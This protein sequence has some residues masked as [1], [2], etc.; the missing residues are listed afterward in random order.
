MGN[1]RISTK[2]CRDLQMGLE[3]RARTGR[4]RVASAGPFSSPC[5]GAGTAR[6]LH[7]HGVQPQRDHK[8][9]VPQLFFELFFLEIAWRPAV[10]PGKF[11]AQEHHMA[12]AR[13]ARRFIKL[14]QASLPLASH[15]PSQPTFLA[16]L[17]PTAPPR[18]SCM[19]LRD[20]AKVHASVARDALP[21][22]GS[23]SK[24]SPDI[25]LHTTFNWGP[26]NTGADLNALILSPFRQ[27][28][29]RVARCR[30]VSPH[31]A[32]WFVADSD[33]PRISCKSIYDR[34]C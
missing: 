30:F 27:K 24:R 1:A 14:S 18:K 17:L 7:A 10:G 31:W 25:R 16:F 32:S 6:W 19:L 11:D 5:P 20:N 22:S 23:Q 12:Q 26:R 13:P 3:T 28:K 33:K 4:K 21:P 9:S 8:S 34:F 15:T 2:S 29:R